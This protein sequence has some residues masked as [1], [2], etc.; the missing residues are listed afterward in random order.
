MS[1]AKKYIVALVALIVVC[2]A[3]IFLRPFKIESDLLSLLPKDFQSEVERET[4][5]RLSENS[6]DVVNVLI[7]ADSEDAAVAATKAFRDNLPAGFA[8][9]AATFPAGD[10]LSSLREFLRPFRFQ[11]LATEQ[12]RLL[13]AGDF[14]QVEEAALAEIYSPVAMRIFPLKDDPYGFAT[15]FLLDGGLADSPFVVRDGICVGSVAGMPT[16][17]LPL[18]MGTRGNLSALRAKME[19]LGEVRNKVEAAATAKIAFAGVPVH[20]DAAATK[21]LHEINFITTASVLA[22]LAI[23]LLVFRSPKQFLTTAATMCLAIVVAATATNCVFGE[24]HILVLVFGCSLIGVSAD[25]IFHLLAAGKMTPAL[26][27]SLAMSAGTTALAFCI[28]FFSGLGVLCQMAT[29]CIVGIAVVL[30]CVMFPLADIPALRGNAPARYA[31]A[32]SRKISQ[33]AG[34]VAA[35]F[36]IVAPIVVAAGIVA[37][38]AGTFSD[39]IRNIYEPDNDL[40]DAE[41]AFA[42]FAG[43][44][45]PARTLIVVGSDAQDVLARQ[46]GLAQALGVKSRSISAL[47]PPISEQRENLR[48]VRE[49]CRHAGDFPLKLPESAL[50]QD[51]VPLTPEAFVAS[52]VVPAARNLFWESGENF[53]APVLL[54]EAPADD[55]LAEL[56][57]KYGATIADPV[58]AISAR[59]A[60]CRE[61]VSVLFA[62]ALALFALIFCVRYGVSRA[63]AMMTPALCAIA[64][65]VALLRLSGTPISLFHMLALFLVLGFGADYVI[66]TAENGGKSGGKSKLSLLLSCLTTLAAFGL[67]ATTTFPVIRE[68]GLAA[69]TGIFACYALTE[70][71]AT[72]INRDAA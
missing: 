20:T 10:N 18:Q 17:C 68:I 19:T 31:V 5:R 59:L 34:I 67:L 66:F 55:V 13:L 32:A 72:T 43:Q 41:K 3:A 48:A 1:R 70:I 7:S 4:I 44:S 15:K 14:R 54:R 56:C 28:F 11:L 57:A 39:D 30:A 52:N 45:A 40:R 8:T 36:R 27:R 6:A 58:G 62:C 42:E 63:T 29:F 71:F 37:F 12:R 53:F 49:L 22:L 24:M 2:A 51:F 25:Y 47:I 65:V 33:A 21:S 50:P 64:I 23:F 60:L 9:P 26:R 35:P 38:F 46:R 16:A 69:A 61:H